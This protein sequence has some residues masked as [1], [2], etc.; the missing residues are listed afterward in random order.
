[1]TITYTS[2]MLELEKL[3]SPFMVKKGWSRYLPEDVP[4]EIKKAYNEFNKLWDHA[5]EQELSFQ[6]GI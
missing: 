4:D 1:M 6:L 5:Y 2:E 3:F